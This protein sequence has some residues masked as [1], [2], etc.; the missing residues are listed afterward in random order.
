[1]YR[2]SESKN[3]NDSNE[4]PDARRELLVIKT[5]FIYS[6]YIKNEKRIS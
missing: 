2:I 4:N 3:N 6:R 5:F 1:M